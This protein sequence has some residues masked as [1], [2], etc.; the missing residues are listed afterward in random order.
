[1]STWS[2]YNQPHGEF[3][4]CQR[5]IVVRL[6]VTAGAVAHFVGTLYVKQ[7]SSF[8]DTKAQLNA[9][10]DAN[11]LFYEF[12][13]AEYCRNYFT[14]E[15]CFYDQAW[16][17]TFDNMVERVFRV[18]I[19]PVEYDS[20][21]NLLPVPTDIL[22]T[23]DFRVIPTNTMARESTS[24]INDNI[25]L[26]KFVLNGDNDS[27]APLIPS[28]EN[29]LLTNMPDYNTIDMSQGF[30][31][32]QNFLHD[33]VAG[34]TPVLELT[35]SSGTVETIEVSTLSSGYHYEHIHPFVI[36][37]LLSLIQG[38]PANFLLSSTGELISDTLSVQYKFNDS[39]NGTLVRSSPMGKY[40]LVD[41]LGCKSTTF[42]FR[43]MRGGFDF[44]TATGEH[45][46]S[47]DISGSEFDR[48]TDFN[49]GQVDFGLI[50]G[51]HNITNLW[52]TRKEMN[53]VFT[54]PVSKEYATWLEE[55]IVSPQVWVVK[56]IKDY[57]GSATLYEN[58]GLVAINILKGSYN[59]HN[60]ENGRHFIEFKYTLSENTTTQKM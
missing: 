22:S 52:S 10:G 50:R 32:F 28:S 27:S 29:R 31:F 13:F 40:K 57:S 35:N 46:V 58:K 11:G 39:T 56:D 5:P 9:Y 53:T 19:Y 51:Q 41:G 25:R 37:T 33:E 14:E 23:N 34:V 44:F 47:V 38:Q 18:V 48:H 3:V 55:L 7:G 12:N 26:D 59:L 20:S 16:C 24:Y 42:I 30:F 36:D 60:T 21:G 6:R 54:Q 4:T 43:N 1:M 15:E 45:D 17:Q 2:I 8:V 49:R